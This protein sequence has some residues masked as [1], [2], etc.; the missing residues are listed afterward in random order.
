[1]TI[2]S[3]FTW[4]QLFP[5]GSHPFLDPLWSTEWC[6][7]VHSGCEADR[8]AK[9]RFIADRHP[10]LL[11][12]V[13]VCWQD[14]RTTNC[15]QCEKCLRTM[16]DFQIAGVTEHCD[17]LPRTIDPVAIRRLKL[18]AAALPFWTHVQDCQSL[19]PSI[20]D[21]ARKAVA[22]SRVSITPLNGT[23]KGVLRRGRDCVRQCSRIV[24][25]ALK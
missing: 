24:A 21:A 6:E 3:T 15:G 20:R 11:K 16:V 23:V 19:P 25:T 8:P 22:D 10:A 12:H 1:V 5:W 2:G 13:R 7:L 17:S 4:A 18:S 9:A 14:G